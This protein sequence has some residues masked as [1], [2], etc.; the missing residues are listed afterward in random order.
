[1]LKRFRAFVRARAPQFAFL[2]AVLFGWLFIQA[3][4]YLVASVYS[5]SAS[6]A[7][8]TSP[9]LT[10]PEDPAAL[11]LALGFLGIV[12]ALPLLAFVLGR[13]RW[14]SFFAI[15]TSA[16][17]RLALTT[18][19]SPSQAL[20]F[21]CIV[22]GAGLLYLA[23][24]IRNRAALVP[25]AFI[26]GLALDQLLRAFGNTQDLSLLPS[27]AN[28]Q[29]GI[30]LTLIGLA[31]LSHSLPQLPERQTGAEA[32]MV[33]TQGT[34]TLWGGIGLG[35]WLYL[36]TSLLALPN[37]IGGRADADY[38]LLV[39]ATLAAT[40]LPIVP[41]LRERAKRWIAPFDSLTR[42]WIWL[43]LVA[44]LLILGLRLP[45]L[46][47]GEFALP[48]GA[49]CLIAAQVAI[50][51]L[52]WW[53][54]RPKEQRKTNYTPLWLMLSA[55]IYA[56]FV[57]ADLFTYEYAFVRN[58][59]PP[60][61]LLNSVLPPLLRGLRGLGVALILVAAFF[62]VFPMI[63]S[64]QRL[65]W[66][67]TARKATSGL[68]LILIAG[69]SG[70]AAFLARPPQVVPVL[71][72]S[73]IRVGTYNIHHGYSERY[74]YDLE[75]IARAI[76]QSGAQVVLLQAVD[77][78][79][80]TSYGVDQ[81]LWLARRLGMDRRFFATNEGMTGLAV[82]SRIPI[83]FADGVL[84]PSLDTQTGL[85]RVQ[86]RPDEGVITLYNTA[87][88]LLLAGESIEQQE[89][90]QRLQL[91]AILSTLESHILSDY[92]GRLGRAILG[93]TFNNVPDSPLMQR[94]ANTGF[95]DPF[96]GSN[97]ALSATYITGEQRARLDYVWLWSESL[98]SSGN[99]V[100]DSPA[101]NHRLAF[102]GVEISR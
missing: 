75:G 4:R 76:Q 32:G 20:I 101:S 39:P 66:S 67:G 84:L 22:V 86:I 43:V 35:A 44:L 102:V 17:A 48:L 90:N 45:R 54:I 25:Y 98:R 26:F 53:F 71:N 5:L 15:L 85:Q 52:L 19:S 93:G 72:E 83:V 70:L 10:P 61:D 58:F 79:R 95:V 64:Y 12:I 18:A 68:A 87:L 78:A 36:Q 13:W 59:A 23:Q 8:L 38:T 37:A 21:A 55:L 80:L 50:V 82:L 49:A 74:S 69:L 40:L 99:G 97:L 51:L 14:L 88:G 31:W 96:A 65:A 56:L 57:L 77:K 46:S 89:R 91:D 92:G 60:L 63:Q 34:L 11:S 62:A 24:L 29:L 16:L 94:L 73:E 100:I 30:S 1:M 33:T 41:A 27:F 9:A 6:A 42:G 81:T 2:E 47:F 28:I 3:L 7:A